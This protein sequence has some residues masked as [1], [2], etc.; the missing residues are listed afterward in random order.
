MPVHAA[1]FVLRLAALLAAEVIVRSTQ[2]AAAIVIGCVPPIA[3]VTL[4][5]M[6][7]RDRTPAEAT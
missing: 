1:L 3:I 6:V 2:F 5:A 7:L 4:I